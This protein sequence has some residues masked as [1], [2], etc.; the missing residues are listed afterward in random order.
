M[1]CLFL[2]ILMVNIY[3]SKSEE[4]PFIIEATIKAGGHGRV[5]KGRSK[6]NSS[7][8]VAIKAEDISSGT[9][10]LNNEYQIYKDLRDGKGIPKIFWFGQTDI[11]FEDQIEYTVTEN[12]Y[13]T[14]KK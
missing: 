10:L 5:F 14:L 6:Y 11:I 12:E 3:L 2:I 4:F 9:Y 8:L 13:G 7:Q 1:Y